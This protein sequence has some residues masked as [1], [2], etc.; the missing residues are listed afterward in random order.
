LDRDYSERQRG[1][2][3]KAGSLRGDRNGPEVRNFGDEGIS[4]LKNSESDNSQ[5]SEEKSGQGAS[6][7]EVEHINKKFSGLLD[8]IEKLSNTVRVH[9]FGS[10]RIRPSIRIMLGRW[11]KGRPWGML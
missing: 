11:V 9:L 3:G 4:D 6:N 8:E 7:K 2:K 5:I 1:S 10:E